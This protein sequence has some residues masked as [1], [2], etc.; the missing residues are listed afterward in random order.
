M[1]GDPL[2]VRQMLVVALALAT[3]ADEMTCLQCFDN[4]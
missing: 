4:S 1:V 3:V 2:V